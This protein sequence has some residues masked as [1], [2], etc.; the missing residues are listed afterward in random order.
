MKKIYKLLIVVVILLTLTGC[1]NTAIDAVE[2]YLDK[3]VNLDKD[4][5]LNVDKIVNNENMTAENSN[6][7]KSLFKKQYQNLKYEI[8][9]EEYNGDEAIISVKVTVFDYYKAQND[10]LLYLNNNPDEFD[11][12]DGI[13]DMD[14]FIK[15]K[16][17][18]MEETT[19]TVDYTIDFYVIDTKDGWKV[20]DM[21][22]SDLDKIHGIYNY[23]S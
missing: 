14:K 11:Y 9:N 1:A 19:D 20:S 12:K 17:K 23:E 4:I 13:Y 6:T 21:S 18:L 2:N 7:Y 22:E 3:Y 5:I 8:E 16:L 10:A 15:Y